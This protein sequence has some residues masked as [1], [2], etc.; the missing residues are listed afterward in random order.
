[1]K[2]QWPDPNSS[3]TAAALCRDQLGASIEPDEAGSSTRTGADPVAVAALVLSIPSALLAT[4][5]IA[6]RLRLLPRVAAWLAALRALPGAAHAHLELPAG[7]RPLMDLHPAEVLDA[8]QAE[9]RPGGPEDYQWDAFLIHA[10]RD[11][12]EA[13]ALWESLVGAQV[14]C[15]LDRA[16]LR[17]GH[18]WPQRLLQGLSQ[19][20]V[21]AVLVGPGAETGW[22]NQD[23]LARAVRLTRADPRR[24]LLPVLL[25]GATEADLPYGLGHIQ[26][27]PLA[28]AKPSI[29]ALLGR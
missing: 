14:D 3:P 8:A 26:P 19:S 10:A 2:L 16:S 17:P 24:A 4:W 22:Y 18:G 15:F 7:P 13:R 23:E 12:A 21:F 20:R 28:E 25:P 1:M 6:E 11:R 5:D 9:A 27:T 29:L